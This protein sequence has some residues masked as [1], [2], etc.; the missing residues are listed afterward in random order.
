MLF[1]PKDIQKKV[2]RLLGEAV[3]QRDAAAFLQVLELDPHCGAAYLGLGNLAM[4]AGQFEEA[5]RYYWEGLAQ[6]PCSY[7]FY[8]ALA[9]LCKTREQNGELARDL[10]TLA[11]QK[12]SDG[13]EKSPAIV[14]LLNETMGQA[15]GLDFHNPEAFGLVANVMKSV[16]R[17]QPV[18]Q[19]LRP[20]LLLQRMQDEMSVELLDEIRADAPGMTPVLEGVLREWTV[21]E[22]AIDGLVLC[23]SVALLGEIGPASA[24]E[25]LLDLSIFSDAGLFLHSQWAIYRMGQ[26]FP[27]ETLQEFHARIPEAPVSLRCGLAEQ[28]SLMPG[29]P[30]G[31]AAARLLLDGFAKLAREEDA[32]YLLAAAAFALGKHGCVDEAGAVIEQHRG[33]LDKDSR[34]AFDT[35]TETGFV[36]RLV[37]EEIDQCDIEDVCIGHAFMDFEDEEEEDEEIPLPPPPPPKPPGRNDPCWCGSGAKYKKCHLSADEQARRDSSAGDAMFGRLF[38]DLMR[39][40]RQWD[41]PKLTHARQAGRLFYGGAEDDAFGKWYVCDFRLDGVAE[42]VLERYLRERDNRL[43][44]RER[45]VLESWRDSLY[46]LYQVQKVEPGRGVEL[47]DLCSSDRMFVHDVSSSRRFVKWD[48][49]LCRL[50]LLDGKWYLGAN[51]LLVPRSILDEFRETIRSE[52]SQAGL[53]EQ[54]WV[55]RNSHKLHGTVTEI[56]A[57]RGTPE[58]RNYEGDRLESC[59]A[60]YQLAGDEAAAIAGL[61]RCPE[62]EEVED[63]NLAWLEPG[64]ADARRSYGTIAIRGGR[65]RLECNSRKRLER[66]RSLIEEHA[67][68]HLKHLGD[69]LETLEAAM[70]RT[71]PEPVKAPTEAEKQ[72]VAQF[73]ERHYRTWP[74]HP[75]PALDGKSPR[76]AMQ[77]AAGK[78]AVAGI[79]RDME[80]NEMRRQDDAPFD[81]SI[82]RASLGLKDEE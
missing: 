4:T 16:V 67:G 73:K 3:K 34:L 58:I 52:A 39:A 81:F 6:Q 17:E 46:S 77:T 44:M 71:K 24:L 1:R 20:Y 55:R 33:S 40:A 13:R 38:Q 80:N 60:S 76:E 23:F 64:G 65:L 54:D 59:S 49:A 70:K 75:L 28:L 2:G 11:F 56:F 32:G 10:T 14:E 78:R 25:N 69:S 30:G 35:F 68:A 18:D 21:D 36:P 61:L 27:E 41:D 22:D 48:C 74:D 63:G 82:L 8:F 72:V 19:R 26:R 66:G 79:I 47:Q 15:A 51:A 9:Q 45:A 31:A 50:E 42:T 7:A 62:F 43:G 29:S 5:E 37:E 57:A 53:S 12:L